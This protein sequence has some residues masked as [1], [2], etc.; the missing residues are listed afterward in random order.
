MKCEASDEF[1]RGELWKMAETLEADA[2]GSAMARTIMGV[3]SDLSSAEKRI[4]AAEKVNDG[5]DFKSLCIDVWKM[6]EIVMFTADLSAGK[7]AT[8]EN[9]RQ[10]LVDNGIDLPKTTWESRTDPFPPR[11]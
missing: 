6:M 5:I 7:L 3:L 8:I 1:D 9:L 4:E 2:P 11:A 10:R